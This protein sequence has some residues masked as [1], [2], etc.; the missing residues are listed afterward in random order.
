VFLMQTIVV[1]CILLF[2]LYRLLGGLAPDNT[3]KT[4]AQ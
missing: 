2:V 3:T 4:V 1:P